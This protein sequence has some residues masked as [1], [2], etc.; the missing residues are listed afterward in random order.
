MAV[1]PDEHRLRASMPIACSI[2]S[3]VSWKLAS[4]QRDAA[5]SAIQRRARAIGWKDVEITPVKDQYSRCSQPRNLDITRCKVVSRCIAH[6]SE[7]QAPG[8]CQAQRLLDSAHRDG[9]AVRPLGAKARARAESAHYLKRLSSMD[10]RSKSLL[11][12]QP[13]RARARE[14]GP[15]EIERS[16]SN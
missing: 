5:C 7:R 16:E 13:A 8:N 4:W 14:F 6:T 15:M 1:I 9:S 2:R 10:T 11:G 3:A 12:A